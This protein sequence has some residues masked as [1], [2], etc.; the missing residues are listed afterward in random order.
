MKYC[1]WNFRNGISLRRKEF[2]AWCGNQLHESTKGDL[3]H[4]AAEVLQ[5]LVLVEL[6][7]HSE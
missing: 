1:Q 6:M 2:I 3:L 5:A 7:I 4:N